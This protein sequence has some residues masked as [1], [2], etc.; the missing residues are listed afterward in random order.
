M[1]KSRSV[2][3]RGTVAAA[4]IGLVVFPTLWSRTAWT[5]QQGRQYTEI[6]GSGQSL[7]NIAIPPVLAGPGAQGQA[8]VLQRVL[9][10]DLTLVGL[11]KV[12]DSR[13]F[14]ANL[15]REGTGINPEAWANV[16]AQAIVKARAVRSGS[17]WRVNWYL[18]EVGR[19]SRPV[20]ARAIV[21]TNPRRIAHRF[22]DEIVRYYTK[23]RGVFLTRIA[24]TAGS[25][26][27]KRS[28]IYVMD[29]DGHGVSRVSRT[30]SQNV[31]PT[32]SRAGRLA[33][34]S[35]LWRNPDL[36]LM[37][38]KGGRAKRISKR[39]GL[40]SGAAFSPD[41]GRIAL[42]LSKDGNAELYLINTAGG[43]VRRLTRHPGIDTSPSWSP[44]GS[45]IAFVSN[46]GGSPQIYVMSASGGSPR[47]VTYAGN[48]NQEP[49]W[50]PRKDTPV[51]AFTGRDASGHYDV[52]TVNVKTGELKRITQGQ[53]NNKSP[54]WAP[55]GRL[56][57]FVSSRGGLWLSNAEGL[58][59]HQVYR[60]F[61]ETPAWSW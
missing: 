16:G 19:G 4:I 61:A 14:L 51:I 44:D 27:R 49:A 26:R 23:D 59:Q 39:P 7:Y 50:C 9:A 42:T 41:G 20:V 60:G 3:S 2:L 21:G 43:I 58:N 56:L 8:R 54:S 57:V 47:R 18:Y 32:W 5:Q 1:R 37:A 24:F 33:Y 45:K 17:K 34:T 22:G 55:N 6:S 31:L 36:Y 48:Y 29:F 35:F 25:R 12:L 52:F 11:F 30:G 40:N 38:G 53:G 10:N 13:G 46:R 28:Y 15:K